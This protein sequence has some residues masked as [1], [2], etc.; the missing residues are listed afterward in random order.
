M[1]NSDNS[2][3]KMFGRAGKLEREIYSELVGMVQ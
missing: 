3:S 2:E 1:K